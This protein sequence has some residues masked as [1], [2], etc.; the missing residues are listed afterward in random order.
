MTDMK[1]GNHSFFSKEDFLR[2]TSKTSSSFKH[3]LIA[4]CKLFPQ[5]REIET[6]LLYVIQLGNN[7]NRK[8]RHSREGLERELHEIRRTE[9]KNSRMF[10]RRM[11]NG[12]E[13]AKNKKTRC[14]EWGTHRRHATLS[15]KCNNILTVQFIYLISHRSS[16]S[17]IIHCHTLPK[18]QAWMR[19]QSFILRSLWAVSSFLL[20]CL[21]KT[22][23]KERLTKKFD[24]YSKEAGALGGDNQT[25]L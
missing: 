19:S 14:F 22:T 7:K 24:I 2:R 12:K 3:S 8:Q 15:C 21:R 16:L 18:N 9:E 23:T 25:N 11:P 6:E 5:S 1:K 13:T 20:F 17:R 10:H 4:L